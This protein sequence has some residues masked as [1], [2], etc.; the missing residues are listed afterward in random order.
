[1]PRELLAG[2]LLNALA[3]LVVGGPTRRT[4]Y[5]RLRPPRGTRKLARP[6]VRLRMNA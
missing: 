6:D 3:G 4:R 5:R 1:M 2:L